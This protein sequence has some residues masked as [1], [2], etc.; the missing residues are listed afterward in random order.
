MDDPHPTLETPCET[1]RGG[2]WSNAALFL[3]RRTQS[4]PSPQFWVL[5]N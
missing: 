5:D 1:L 4:L 3:V 2:D